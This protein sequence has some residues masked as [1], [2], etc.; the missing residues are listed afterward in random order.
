MTEPTT[1]RDRYI[2][3]LRVTA[4]LM[5][6]IP[7]IPPPSLSAH[8]IELTW[9]VS[10]SHPDPGAELARLARLMPCKLTKNKPGD[11]FG[12]EYYELRGE[13]DGV[14]IELWAKRELVC[15]K[16]VTGTRPVTKLVPD[17]AAAMVE[18]T[19]EEDIVEWR[20]DPLLAKNPAQAAAPDSSPG[21]A[22]TPRD[23]APGEPSVEA[24]S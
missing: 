4:N 10:S 5:E 2:R 18:V 17:P 8:T 3:A 15:T 14:P 19:E 7:D 6:T 12:D 11:A 20:C 13:I 24:V 1:R 21:A 16:V 9:S 23:A 22:S